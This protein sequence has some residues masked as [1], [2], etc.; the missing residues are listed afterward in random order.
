M[1]RAQGSRKVE[2]GPRRVERS[3]RAH[4]RRAKW[5]VVV[6]A[7][8]CAMVVAAAPAVAMTRT[9][10]TSRGAHVS[11]ARHAVATPYSISPAKPN[12]L[13]IGVIG[14][15][16]ISYSDGSPPCA[17]ARCTTH[18]GPKDLVFL[19][20]HNVQG[21]TFKRW[22][23]GC[24]GDGPIC[25][26]IP[27]QTPKVTA[28]FVHSG[29]LELTVAG[30]GVITG[31]HGK[32]DCG[33]NN[34]LC[35]DT[36]SGIGDTTFT[37]HAANDATFLGWGGSCQ[38]YT[39]D[40]CSVANDALVGATA[41]F[42]PTSPSSGAQA[43]NVTNGPV[44]GATGSIASCLSQ[45]DCNTMVASGTSLTLSREEFVADP[46]VALPFLNWSGG[47]CV[48]NW[49]VCSLVVDGPVNIGFILGE[50]LAASSQGV[51]LLVEVNGS[52]R[53]H[54]VR[55]TLLHGCGSRAQ[56]GGYTCTLVESHGGFAIRAI[57][58]LKGWGATDKKLCRPSN[59]R[60]CKGSVPSE[61]QALAV[62]FK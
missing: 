20:A 60:E 48:G 35:T 40:D 61:G 12:G 8:G 46:F 38:Q 18:Q 11:L 14:G 31:D 22:T 47:E 7:T 27:G 62:T 56:G 45:V 54:A 17:S 42:A 59:N 10:S 23:K 19:T 50:V 3:Q 21:F 51:T 41:T 55:G 34:S 52:G 26:V 30:P 32:I 6:L 5:A 15:G 28:L 9:N 57:G 37:P 29:T 58:N 39:T 16:F 1:T 4:E 36:L 25:G 44:S 24:V 2:G 49:P 43:F 33:G 13:T 53:L